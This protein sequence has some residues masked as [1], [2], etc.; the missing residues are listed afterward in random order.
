[1]VS[2]IKTFRNLFSIACLSALCFSCVSGSKGEIKLENVDAPMSMSPHLYGPGG[3]NLSI[4]NGLEYLGG[5][6][7]FKNYYGILGGIIPLSNDK[8]VNET[9]QNK[10]KELDGDGVVNLY[11]MVSNNN[12]A[13]ACC[14]FMYIPFWP[15]ATEVKV[16]GDVVKYTGAKK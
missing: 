2:K 6:F 8:D 7:F 3:E 4:D 14:L 1:M 12:T 11:F 15:G 16:G 9:I 13:N 10:I 5:F